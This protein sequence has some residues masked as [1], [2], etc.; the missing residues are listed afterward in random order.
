MSKRG[1][2]WVVMMLRSDTVDALGLVSH[3]TGRSRGNNLLTMHGSGPTATPARHGLRLSL[4]YRELPWADSLRQTPSGDPKR[5]GSFFNLF[6][7]LVTALG[8]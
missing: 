1:D 6:L 7:M 4:R 5:I 8:P 2:S 3:D